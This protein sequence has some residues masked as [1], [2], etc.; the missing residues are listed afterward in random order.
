MKSLDK[1]IRSVQAFGRGLS[2]HPAGL[3]SQTAGVG[4]G[5][6]GRV[7]IG[8]VAGIAI[9]LWSE[10]FRTKGYKAF[11]YSLKAVGFGTLVEDLIFLLSACVLFLLNLFPKCPGL[12]LI[13]ED[14][15]SRSYKHDRNDRCNGSPLA[16]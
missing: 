8:L 3:G 2:G 1:I 7:T 4:I 9:I 15:D 6:A 13:E 11:S 10:R 12:L 16:P 14:D 5:L